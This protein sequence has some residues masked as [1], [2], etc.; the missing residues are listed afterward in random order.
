MKSTRKRSNMLLLGILVAVF[1]VQN[2]ANAAA[3][4]AGGNRL[5]FNVEVTYMTQGGTKKTDTAAVLASTPSEAERGAEAQFKEKNARGTFIRA[6]A[7]FARGEKQT[8]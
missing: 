7:E 1:I 3:Q 2:A 8:E 5:M 4:D 6:K